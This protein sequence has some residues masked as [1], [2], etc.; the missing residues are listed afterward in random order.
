MIAPGNKLALTDL[1]SV[2][3]TANGLSSST[4]DLTSFFNVS[5]MFLDL[6]SNNY[7]YR[8]CH[9]FSLTA[10]GSGYHAGDQVKLGT[11]LTFT[12]VTVTASGAVLG[13]IV[14]GNSP[15]MPGGTLVS[16]PAWPAYNDP[17]PG[18]LST[19]TGSG[20][21][22]A[23]T[24]S[25]QQVGPTANYSFPDYS[26]VG[27]VTGLVVTAGGTG[28]SVSDSLTLAELPGWSATVATVSSGVITSIT[29]TA[30]SSPSPLPTTIAA[31]SAIGGHGSGGQAGRPIHRAPTPAMANRT[32]PPADES[33]ECAGPGDEFFQ[34][35]GIGH[36][37]PVADPWSEPQLPQP[38]V[39]V[40]GHRV[41]GE[42]PYHG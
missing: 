21:G 33:V 27:T 16:S 26:P 17:V 3:T 13:L 14:T 39:L 2:A 41:I 20:S 37:R 4:F 29:F 11:T 10:G 22:A 34:F 35:H 38:G 36:F 7:G 9:A 18:T 32:E 40:S 12:V 15:I 28:Y 23:I 24:F 5:P 1:Q 19:V 25:V 8:D 31:M 42:H 6:S 30:S